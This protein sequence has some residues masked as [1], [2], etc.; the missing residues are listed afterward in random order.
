MKITKI[1]ITTI[2]LI[3]AWVIWEFSVSKWAETESGPI[4]RVDLVII[5]PIMLIMLLISLYQ[6]FK[7]NK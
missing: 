3:I 1:Q 4:I 6:L 5:I 7:K 2:L